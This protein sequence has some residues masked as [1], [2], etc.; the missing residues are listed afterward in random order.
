MS[1]SPSIDFQSAPLHEIPIHRVESH[2]KTNPVVGAR[3]QAAAGRQ[4]SFFCPVIAYRLIPGD[5][6]CRA[7]VRIDSHLGERERYTSASPRLVVQSSDYS[8]PGSGRASVARSPPSSPWRALLVS[9]VADARAPFSR[10]VVV[11]KLSQED[12][13]D[14]HVSH[15]SLTQRPDPGLDL[16]GDTC[17]AAALRHSQPSRQHIQSYPSKNSQLW[18]YIKRFQTSRTLRTSAIK[19]RLRRRP[20][21]T[22][23]DRPRHDSY[24]AARA[25]MENRA[26]GL[27]PPV[28]EGQLASEDG[29]RLFPLRRR[30]PRIRA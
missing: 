15:D 14:L 28:E 29:S 20:N 30:G 18:L 7:S 10:S 21:P 27:G 2:S 24:A 23:E 19:N 16:R 22:T 17:R 8:E 5:V 4:A 1:R 13:G 3:Y 12:A 11:H 25:W 9:D 6:S 26:E